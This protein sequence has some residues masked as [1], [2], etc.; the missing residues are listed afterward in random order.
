M[1]MPFERFKLR[2]MTSQVVTLTLA[3]DDDLVELVAVKDYLIEP[4]IVALQSKLV[5][6]N[7]RLNMFGVS[8]GMMMVVTLTALLACCDHHGRETLFECLKSH[9]PAALLFAM[10][11]ILRRAIRTSLTEKF[12]SHEL[13]Q[14]LAKALAESFL[15]AAA[16]AA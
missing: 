12:A 1:L 8:I 2:A 4:G 6:K 14:E 16:A 9:I 15:F 11:C 3:Q 7:T 13:R 10:A 5:E